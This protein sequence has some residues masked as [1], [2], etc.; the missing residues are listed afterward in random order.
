MRWVKRR[1][2]MSRLGD[3]SPPREVAD[4]V[5]TRSG[6]SIAQHGGLAY[7]IV[8]H[9]RWVA[10]SW[11]ALAAALLPWAAHVTEHLDVAARADGSESDLVAR[12][13]T[14]RFG[15]PFARSAILVATG[16]PSPT[17]PDGLDA[18]HA[19]EASLQD[20]PGVVRTLSY[21]DIPDTLFLGARGA[22]TFVVVGLDAAT[23]RPDTLISPLRA[24]TARVADALSALYP[25]VALR[26][27]GE[28]ALNADLRGVS[29]SD[30]QRAER[31]ALPVT[32][33]L[34]VIAF[35]A[36]AAAC[37][38]LLSA[39]LAIGSALGAAALLAR[40][41]PLSVL[42]QNVVTMLGLGFGTD[43]ALLVVSRF[44]EAR[45][46]GRASDD[47]AEDAARHTGPTIA[48]SGLAAG[49]GFLALLAVPLGELRSIAIG[50]LLIVGV[51]VAFATTAL[52]GILAW[53]GPGIDRGRWRTPGASRGA[54]WRRWGSFVATHPALV[55]AL[56]GVP[57]ALLALQ[58]TRL[59][60]EL[61]RGEWLPREMESAL[62][63]HDLQA[64]RRSG[65]VQEIRVVLELPPG[66]Q[67]T[68]DAGWTATR[69]LTET[70]ATD[71]AAASVRSL[72]ALAGRGDGLLP[73]AAIMAMIP[74]DMRRTFASRDGRAALVEIAPREG[75]DYELFLVAR[76]R[77]AR[78]A[79]R[80]ER[81]AIAEG[82]ARTG[83]II[84][85]AAAIMIV[86]FGA[87]TLGGFLLMKMLGFALAVAVL[88]DTS[89]MRVAV[90]P[91]LLALAG[92]WN[93]WPG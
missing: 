88:L 32:L 10:A 24:R 72:P 6:A 4:A 42:L 47:A 1:D 81:E 51:S 12:E 38:P 92:R 91:A 5:T 54:G 76:V 27:T 16:I 40:A 65:V 89:I 67:A 2:T 34:L 61:P 78:R 87:F 56:F 73:R 26:W 64:M 48:L 13:L 79:G 71:P 53:I 75:M 46:S 77:E 36:I 44:R 59:R 18:L 19:I 62:A 35:G 31:R 3:Y 49:I 8:R 33:L 22:G 20:A 55:L 50:G 58:A 37:L 68:S 7:Q 66:T 28:V 70:L 52:P 83:G 86:V 85:S 41:W 84:T 93:W 74:E 57:V 63:L 11:V 23:R 60:T 29:A 30:A 43:Y 90:G 69:H 17:G 80:D 21:A 82:L 39:L 15:S 25:A 45:A 9:R 14:T